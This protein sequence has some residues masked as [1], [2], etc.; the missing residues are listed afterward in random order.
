MVFGRLEPMSIKK[1]LKAL[2]MSLGFAIF[3]PST[4]MMF[5]YELCFWAFVQ[6]AVQQ[7]FHIKVVLLRFLQKQFEI[8][9]LRFMYWK[10]YIIS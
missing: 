8:F 2:A 5:F 6:Q 9:I 3:L 1:L 10:G 7:P 4:M